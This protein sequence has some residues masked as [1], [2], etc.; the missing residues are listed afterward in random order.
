MP[1]LCRAQ[2][3]D[4]QAGKEIASLSHTHA[5]TALQF[6]PAEFILASACKDRCVRFWG[7]N[8]FDLVDTC[9]P[10]ATAA[11]AACFTRDGSSLLA[12]YQ[13]FLKVYTHEPAQTLGHVDAA[14]GHV[15]DMAVLGSQVVA[16]SINGASV[17]IWS[18][19]VPDSSQDAAA[20]PPAAPV[21]AAGSVTPRVSSGRARPESANEMAQRQQVAT[22]A[23]ATASEA[24]GTSANGAA[25]EG[26]GSLSGGGKLSQV[27]A[28]QAAMQVSCILI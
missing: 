11:K 15:A 25:R 7:L 14:F 1:T 3:W 17:G 13:D 18:G 27:Q 21:Q 20:A 26:A 16:C 10:E 22:N 2:V 19:S 9:G 5:V 28:A 23:A 8:D 4:L 6:N 12:A 24:K